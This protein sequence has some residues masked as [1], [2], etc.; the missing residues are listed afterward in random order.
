[1]GIGIYL[2]TRRNTRPREEHGSAKWGEAAAV[3]RKYADKRFCENKILTQHVRIGFNAHTHRRNLN[4]MIVGGS[5]S[6]KTRFYAKPN[7]MQTAAS[8]LVILDPKGE[9][10]RDTGHLLKASGMEV[11][12]LDLINMH[13][14]HCY[15]PFV[16]LRDDNDV[17]RLVTNLFKSTTPKGAQTQD[18]FWDT[19]AS[20]LLLALMFYLKYEAPPDE[21]N[22]SMVMEMLR[23]GDVRE[24]DDSYQSPLDELFDRLEMRNENHIAVKYYRDYRSGSAKTLKSIQITLAA[25]LEKFNLESLAALTVTDELDLE[26]IGEKR[27]VL[28]I[29]IPDN[30]SSFNFLVSILYTQLF[31]QLFYSADHKHGGSL[32]THVHFLMDEFANVSLPDDFDKIL[33]VMR[34]RGVS[35]SI[36]LQNMAQLKALFEKQWESIVGNCDSFLFLGSGGADTTTP[37]M[38]SELLGKETLDTNTYGKS[39]GRNGNYSTNYQITGRELLTPDEVRMLDNRYALLFIRGELPILDDKYDI[40]RHPNVGGT[41]DG[42][43]GRF[44][45][46][47]VTESVATLVFDEDIDPAKLPEVTLPDGEEYELLSEED[48]ENLF[49]V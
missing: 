31:Q 6:G 16:Y 20:M 3:N 19:A 36:I 41:A 1:M 40:L 28:F 49:N 46:G 22:F 35:V 44:M 2:S 14:S 25:R 26:S 4:V 29:I 38:V 7:V 17:Q 23:A 24:D 11:K 45:H 13:R 42:K 8:S 5:G 43:A 10:A 18:P 33:S 30:D 32:P 9:I 48:L 39:T 47:E 27:T 15:N 37:K 12:V 34:S 21:Q